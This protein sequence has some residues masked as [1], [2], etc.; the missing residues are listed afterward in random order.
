[1]TLVRA[2]S[3]APSSGASMPSAV[4]TMATIDP[5]AASTRL[6]H[7]ALDG[8]PEQVVKAGVH[9][10]EHNQF[11]IEQVD[12]VG[13]SEPQPTSDRLQRREYLRI[14][15]FGAGD[16]PDRSTLDHL[17]RGGTE[18]AQQGAFTG[19]RLPA[20]DRAAP[21]ADPS[22]IDQRVARLAGVAGGAEARLAADDH[23]DPDPHFTGHE[24][25]VGDPGGDAAAVLAEG[26][27]IGLVGDRDRRVA[28][29]SFGEHLAER[30]VPPSEVGGEVH[31]AVGAPRQPDDRDADASEVM[32]ARN[33]RQAAVRRV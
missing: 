31:E 33:R 1:M 28:A 3:A 14:S 25:E 20:S 17:P 5:G 11:G 24:Q 29:E 21:A 22:G 8:G 7:S 2:S 9:P 13:N 30:H 12:E 4:G 18:V 10:A 23:A 32:F 16:R 26:A 27:E 19:L 15:G 6:L